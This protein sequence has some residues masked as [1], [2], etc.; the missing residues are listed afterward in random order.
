MLDTP[1]AMCLSWGSEMALIYNDA[2]APFLGLRHPAA[3]GRPFAEVWHDV[4]PDVA[5]LVQRALA[6]EQVRQDDMHLLM[7][8]NGYDEST[9]WSFCYSPARDDDGVV[10][11]MLNIATDSTIRVLAERRHAARLAVEDRFRDLATPDAIMAAA[12]HLLATQLGDVQV[13]YGQVLADDTTMRISNCFSATLLPHAGDYPLDA[14]GAARIMRQRTGLTECVFDVDDIDDEAADAW[15]MIATRAFVSV[16]LINADRFTASLFVNAR[17]PRRWRADEIEFIEDVAA[18][19]WEAIRRMRAEHRLRGESERMTRMFDQAP[20]FMAVLNGPD[21]RFDYANPGYMRLVGGRDVV[22]KTVAEA[23]P[24]VELQGFIGLLDRVYATAQPYSAVG[25][26]LVI[27]QPANAPPLERLI[28]FVYQPIADAD[29][30][31]VG[32]FVEGTDVTERALA[33]AALRA[34]EEELR[35]L[36]IDLERKVIERSHER[37]L[38]WHHSPDLLSVIDLAT[39]NFDKVNPAWVATLGWSFEQLEGQGVADFVHADDLEASDAGMAVLRGGDP[40]LRFENRYRTKSGDWRWLSWVAVPDSGKIYA[41]ARDVTA[42]RQRQSEL[43][44]AQSALLQSQ[45]LEAMGQLTG[46]VAHDFNNLLTP[47]I[48]SLDMLFRRGVGSDRERRLI[49]GALQSAERAKVLVQRL[50]AFARRQPLQTSA[51]DLRGLL[52][53][54]ADL[55]DSTSGPAISVLVDVPDYLPPAKVDGNQLAMAVLN[56]AV[57]ARDAMPVGGTLTIS[58]RLETLAGDNE[59]ALSAGDYIR[60]GVTDTG[61]G[62]DQDTIARAV[63][64]FFSTKGVGKGTGLGLSMVHGLAAQMSGAMTLTSTVGEGTCVELWLPISGE[65]VVET[66]IE[67]AIPAQTTIGTVL[68]VDDEPL[69]R[70]CTA[71]MLLDLG[72]QVVEAGSAEAALEHIRAGL[73]PDVTITDHL[74]PG[75]NGDDLASVLRDLRP[76][77]PVLL[78]SGYANVEGIAPSLPRLTKPFRFGDLTTSL[79]VFFPKLAG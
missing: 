78:I 17:V 67:I 7:N 26:R 74:M 76:G 5:P 11:G 38:V 68:L 16:P 9:W 13:S 6:G 60:L 39:G 71:D 64:P 1:Q 63:E 66:A 20:S 49:D 53:G 65:P 23:L 62:M 46:G 72:F 50:L 45:K 24:E 79:A 57:N 4:W 18:R 51:V 30:S 31:I 36:N 52:E 19:S 42:D 70:M 61:T 14:F 33:E 21:H 44:V 69:V 25:M 40:V 2:Y 43:E 3:L 48:G 12:G 55:I 54:M 58:A 75:M 41:S 47:I 27:L 56:L 29:G 59:L 37:G 10:Q 15:A 35:S 77:M 32:I 73:Q 28:D 34:S 22:G 8:R